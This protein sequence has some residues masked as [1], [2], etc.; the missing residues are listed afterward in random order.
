LSISFASVADTFGARVATKPGCA[1][2]VNQDFG[3]IQRKREMTKEDRFKYYA[4]REW[5][6]LKEAVKE[7]SGGHCERCKV[8]LH[9]ST[10]HLTYERFGCELLEDLQGVCGPCHEFLSGKTNYDP[11]EALIAERYDRAYW[12]VSNSQLNLGFLHNILMWLGENKLAEKLSDVC[13]TFD[14]IQDLADGK[15]SKILF[16]YSEYWNEAQQ[17][18][19]F[20]SRQ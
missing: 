11:I 15:Y 7:R 9:E 14:E 10:H 3:N 2:N 12:I 20:Y 6:V 18:S 4:S 13:S 16:E 1:Q 17:T 19:E 5:A 8:G